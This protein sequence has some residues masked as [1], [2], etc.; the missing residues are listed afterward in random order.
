MVLGEP[1]PKGVQSTNRAQGRAVFCVVVQK[2]EETPHTRR[3][4]L[5][6][7]DAQSLFAAISC[8]DGCSSTPANFISFLH[9]GT[10]KG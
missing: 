3:N 5:S 10:L 2:R 7:L 4:C 6:A 8:A 1:L 9:P